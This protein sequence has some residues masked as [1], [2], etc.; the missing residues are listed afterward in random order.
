MHCAAVM[1]TSWWIMQQWGSVAEFSHNALVRVL[2]IHLISI[3]VTTF[4]AYAY[5]K[6]QARHGNYRIAER[7]LHSLTLLGGTLA[8]FTA[9]RLL[10]HKNRK[11][12]FQQS[13]WIILMLQC[14]VA[15]AV[16]LRW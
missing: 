1:A 2:G 5:D 13:F 4:A 14:I 7:T 12:Y 9:Q 11:R 16:L 6:Y 10:R 8:A 3:N 15:A